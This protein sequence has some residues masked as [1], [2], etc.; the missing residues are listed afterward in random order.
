KRS[1]KNQMQSILV[2]GVI[3]EM[4]QVHG[5]TFTMGCSPEQDFCDKD[6]TPTHQV[7]LSD[8]YIGKYE[9]TQL[10]WYAIMDTLPSLFRGASLP[11]ESV[12]WNDCQKFIQRLNT[13]TGKNFSLPTEAQWEYAAR[14]GKFSKNTRYAGSNN[15]DTV[16]WYKVNAFEETHKVGTKLPNELGIYDMSGNIWEWCLDY[17]NPY[18]PNSQVNPVSNDTSIHRVFRGGG[19]DLGEKLCRVSRRS[20]F[21]PSY[22]IHTIGLRLVLLP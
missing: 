18:L 7:T 20:S 9:V 4:Q 12:S 1:K 13:L 10:Q 8:F 15:P 17:Y 19:W 14:G 21:D 2:N 3:F 11:V 22:A 5:G 6:E 16:A